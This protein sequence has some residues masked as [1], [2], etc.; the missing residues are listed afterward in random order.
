MAGQGVFEAVGLSQDT[1]AAV[2]RVPLFQHLSATLTT[3]DILTDE[4]LQYIEWKERADAATD[5]EFQQFIRLAREDPEA[6]AQLTQ[7]LPSIRDDAFAFIHESLQADAAEAECAQRRQYVSVL[8]KTLE[9]V[10]ERIHD[11]ERALSRTQHAEAAAVDAARRLTAS[12]ASTAVDMAEV[13]KRMEALLRK[14]EDWL[15]VALPLDEQCR[16][17]EL[18]L[19]DAERCVTH[20]FLLAC[21]H[22]PVIAN[23]YRVPP[24]PGLV[25]LRVKPA[26][27]SPYGMCVAT[28]RA[29][30]QQRPEALAERLVRQQAER[31]LPSET[32]FGPSGNR[33]VAG[34]TPQLTKELQA[35][36]A[37]VST[38]RCHVYEEA[39]RLAV[40]LAG[41]EEQVRMRGAARTTVPVGCSG[42][43]RARA[44][45]HP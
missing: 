27:S 4:D 11:E 17:V 36:A 14:P 21:C 9:D 2:S 13:T 37:E 20:S 1:L 40:E 44:L 23:A 34:L 3:A 35:R 39:D 33:G 42:A 28:R 29:Q 5:A 43:A 18:A 8:Q 15:L 41:L 26:W 45:P 25:A 32:P 19:Q 22:A 10:R 6:F 24:H 16:H 7:D 12:D 38:A 31:G 30:H